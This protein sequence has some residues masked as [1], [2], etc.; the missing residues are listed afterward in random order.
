MHCG[1]FIDVNTFMYTNITCFFYSV[2]SSSVGHTI[3][4]ING[5][6]VRG[7]QLE[8]GRDVLEMIANPDNYPI[9]IKFGR[10]KLSTNERIMLASMFHS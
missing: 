6:L 1:I 4:G 5:E 10:P 7:R 9:A 3:L 8:D 2:L